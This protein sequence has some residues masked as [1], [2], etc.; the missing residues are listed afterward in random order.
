MKTSQEKEPE[1]Y[2]GKERFISILL[3]LMFWMGLSLPPEIF[4]PK[5]ISSII[6]HLII[7]I[8]L[9]YLVTRMIRQPILDQV[10][11]KAH[12][13]PNILRF[14]S[15]GFYLISQMLIAGFDV[16]RRVMRADPDI[17]PGV[18]I[19]NTPFRDMYKVAINANSITLTPGTITIDVEPNDKGTTFLVHAISKEGLDA[20]KTDKGFVGK[21]NNIYK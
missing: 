8:P 7:G 21:I 6:Q 16:A 9:S 20:I 18:I 15:Y 10:E 3:L 2:Q 11:I 12:R 1:A 4:T 13:L 17:S 5:G 19:V 14:I